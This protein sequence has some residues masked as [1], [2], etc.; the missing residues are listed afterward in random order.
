[1]SIATGGVS[2]RNL[3]RREISGRGIAGPLSQDNH[4]ESVGRDTAGPSSAAPP[5]Q[6]KLVERSRARSSTSPSTS[7]SARR[8]WP[9]VGVTLSADDFRQRDAPPGF[10]HRFCAASPMAQVEYTSHRACTT[11]RRKS[12]SPGTTRRLALPGPSSEP[13]LSERDRHHRAFER[14][15]GRASAVERVRK[16]R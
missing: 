1:M 7:G 16:V 6:G 5:T 10:A 8:R 9:W 11:P 14:A 13:I 15:P 4:S 2:P 12:A 3:S